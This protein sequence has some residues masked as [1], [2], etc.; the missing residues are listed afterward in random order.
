MKKK[1]QKKEVA[2]VFTSDE[3]MSLL[4]HIDDRIQSIIEAGKKNDERRTNRLKKIKNK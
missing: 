4:R 1:I 2:M 3:V